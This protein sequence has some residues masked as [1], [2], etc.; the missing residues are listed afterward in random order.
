MEVFPALLWT[1][2]RW[3]PN[4]A[5]QLVENCGGWHRPLGAPFDAAALS[6]FVSTGR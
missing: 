3:G 5:N 2:K 4:E 1:V 6:D